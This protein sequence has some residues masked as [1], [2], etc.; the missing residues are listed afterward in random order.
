[1]VVFVK[2]IQAHSNCVEHLSC[3]GTK[4]EPDEK[5]MDVE[6]VKDENSDSVEHN[7]AKD[8]P[9]AEEEK[10]LAPSKPSNKSISSF[11]GKYVKG[12]IPLE[13]ENV[14]TTIHIRYVL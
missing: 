5:P 12:A 11:F 8:A 1:M 9:E 6:E 7:V 14:Y 2:A 3:V 10:I 4:E 13:H